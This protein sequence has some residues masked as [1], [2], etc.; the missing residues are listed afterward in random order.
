MML[1]VTYAYADINERSIPLKRLPVCETWIPEGGSWG[2]VNLR[3]RD[4]AD[5]STIEAL[6]LEIRELK[7]RIEQL[8]DEI[9]T[10]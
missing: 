2:C 8:E 9:S 6:I 5:R 10:R 1:F 3:R 4:M 7:A